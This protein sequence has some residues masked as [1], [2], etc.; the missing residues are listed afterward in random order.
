[1]YVKGLQFQNFR[2]LSDD[3]I[4]PCEG[5]NVIYG[6]NAQGKTNILEALWLFCGGHSFRASRENELVKYGEKFYKL[7]VKFFSQD[8]EQDAEI[9]FNGGKREVVINGVKKASSTALI[10]RYTAVIFS[11]EDMT[12]VKRGPSARRRFIDS[13]ICRE[14]FQ[15]AVLLA[16]YNQTL[17]QRNALLKDIFRHPELKKTLDIWDD[18]LCDLGAAIILQRLSYIEKLSKKAREYHFGIS[19]N[20]EELSLS[21]ISTCAA[22]NGDSKSEIFEKLK[23][24]LHESKSEDFR[25]GYT[26]VGPHRDDFDIIIND[27]KAKIFASQG[28]QRSAVL[29]LKLAEAQV[30]SELTG[31]N[32]VILLDDVLSEL[33]RKR[34]D[35]LLNKING[36]QVFITCCDFEVNNL[37]GEGKKFLIQ[38]G[39]V[40]Q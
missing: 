2:N 8:R 22:E 6:N 19:D 30:L 23:K 15:N 38:N 13:A 12:L 27:R 16:K 20:T 37:L 10:G 40:K 26:N 9:I 5:I 33:D 25:S 34:Q 24:S 18:T 4:K 11:P 32:P 17:N 31:E 3:C 29:S 28:Q 35:F 36:Y 21:Y 7:K 39:E 14:K 1:M